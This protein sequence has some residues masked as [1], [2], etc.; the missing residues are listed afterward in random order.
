MPNNKFRDQAFLAALTGALATPS[1][2]CTVES[3]VRYAWKIAD[4]A[5]KQRPSEHTQD[6]D[7]V[8]YDS[9]EPV[10]VWDGRH[11]INEDNFCIT[12]NS[13]PCKLAGAK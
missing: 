9:R 1:S 2:N 12:C 4:E 6:N 8:E 13:S 3:L 5:V 11:M 7:S 10:M